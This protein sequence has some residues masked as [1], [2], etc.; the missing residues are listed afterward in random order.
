[1]MEGI[2]ELYEKQTSLLA[3][4]E[5]ALLGMTKAENELDEGEL[6]RS[7]DGISPL[8]PSLLADWVPHELYVPVL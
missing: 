4:K 2:G 5:D 6:S 3:P 8:V 1:M 7:R